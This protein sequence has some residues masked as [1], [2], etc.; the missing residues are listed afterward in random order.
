MNSPDLTCTK[1]GATASFV[2]INGVTCNPPGW[3]FVTLQGLPIIN[4]QLCPACAP[5]VRAYIETPPAPTVSA[6]CACG[7]THEHGPHEFELDQC[8]ELF[9]G[10][11]R[12]RYS[13]G[14]GD[15]HRS[16]SVIWTTVNV[17]LDGAAIAKAVGELAS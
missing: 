13:Y 17:T 4:G 1:C 15:E 3:S 9:T 12:C 8:D 2:K 5:A 11:R 14:H 6:G 16:G 7:Q 10:G